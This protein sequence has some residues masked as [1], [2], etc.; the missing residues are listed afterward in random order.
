VSGANFSIAKELV[1]G[2]QNDLLATQTPFW[3]EIPGHRP[4]SFDEAA[5]GALAA[6]PAGS[7]RSR[8]LEAVAR[9]L[10]KR[11]AD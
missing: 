8:L 5:T 3:E 7:L 10:S 6:E 11:P 1:E 4:T 2:L 9:W